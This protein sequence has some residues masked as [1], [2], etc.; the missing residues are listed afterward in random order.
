MDAIAD[1]EEPR[2]DL[3]E[4]LEDSESTPS[5]DVTAD[6]KE[7]RDDLLEKLTE[8]L[9][10]GYP[11]SRYYVPR[12][13]LQ[14]QVT[15]ATIKRCLPD[16]QDEL[17]DFTLSSARKIF[18]IL[19]YAP[20]LPR[21]IKLESVLQTC[22]DRR[23]TD[24][25]LPLREQTEQ[26]TCT[27]DRVFCRHAVARDT[28]KGWSKD[29]WV[30]FYSNQW[31]FL[32]LEFEANKFDYVLDEQ[33]ILPIKLCDGYSEGSFGEVRAGELNQDHIRSSERVSLSLS[34]R[35]IIANLVI[36]RTASLVV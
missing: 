1:A 27:E 20:C 11:E 16:A 15:Q 22:K 25:I 21:K 14:E 3:T 7:A 35:L 13:C 12:S 6:A 2:S 32:A 8:G 18:A 26:C 9:L 34:G 23:I 5:M 24:E 31:K 33:S 19:L 17:L 4:R 36:Y 10:C 28:L 30:Q 29:G